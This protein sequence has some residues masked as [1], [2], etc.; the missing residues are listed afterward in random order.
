MHITTAKLLT[1]RLA[2][3]VLVLTLLLSVV[4]ARAYDTDSDGLPDSWEMMYFG[5]LWSGT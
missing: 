3:P 1:S 2:L 5:G 4:S